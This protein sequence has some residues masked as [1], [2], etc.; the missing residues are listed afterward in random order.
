M[1]DQKTST[2]RSAAFGLFKD[3][4]M[5][6]AFRRT[7]EFMIEKAAEIGEC[8][9]VA[10][11]IDE[12]DGESWIHEWDRLAD[13]VQALGYESQ[14]AGH[15]I[16]ARECYM[17][18][19]NYYRTAEYGT[20]PTHPQFQEIWE[21]SVDCFRKGAVLF[22]PPVQ[23]IEVHFEDM[24]LPG[25]FWRPKEDGRTRPTLIAAGGNDS[26]LEEVV[27][28]VGM[29]AVRRGYNFFTFDHPGHRGA[30][31][32]YNNCIKRPDYENPYRAAI[33]FLE[34]LPGVDERLAMTGYSFGGYVTCRVAAYEQRLQA[35]APNS[36]VINLFEAS[37]AFGGDFSRMLK[38]IELMPVSLLK[39]L[40]DLQLR[41]RPVLQAFKQ[42]TDW[43][44]GFYPTELNPAEKLEAYLNFLKPFTVKERLDHIHCATIA[45]VSVGDGEVLIKQAKELVEKIP[46]PQKR[47]HLFTMETDGSDDHCQLDNRSRGA[48]VMFDFFD[49]V[50][51]YEFEST[52]TPQ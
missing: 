50:F 20:S 47:L 39:W 9:Y 52:I 48:Q 33:D 11:R 49:D 18:A 3:K 15:L 17:R 21:K 27:W 4:E 6:W 37:M 10:R 12:T 8:L 36:P 32:R 23:C 19:S 24:S 26:C 40:S 31:H 29:A 22:S 35:I 30:V 41:K 45:L 25:Y 7:L 16:S 5:D 38:L 42:Y 51:N 13:R 14:D 2:A 44:S 1:A 28:W 46:S 34:T 43:T